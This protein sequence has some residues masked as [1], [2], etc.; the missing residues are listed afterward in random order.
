[1]TAV[2]V[3]TSYS[4][5]APRLA[6]DHD[7]SSQPWMAVWTRSRHE[8]V[9]RDHLQR[10]GIEVFL[11]LVTRWSR[12]RDRRCKVDWP[13]FPGYCFARFTREHRLSVLGSPGVVCLVSFDGQPACIPDQEIA[14]IRRLLA[15]GLQYDALPSIPAGMRARVIAGPLAGV[16]GLVMRRGSNTRLVLS[17][18]LIHAAVSVEVDARDVCRA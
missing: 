17:V 16:V 13:L 11:P 7:L 3:P 5:A 14:G 18:E 8:Q 10:K 4:D 1:M 15:T 9:V 6:P 2:N 12:R